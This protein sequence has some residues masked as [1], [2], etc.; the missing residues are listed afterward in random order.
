VLQFYPSRLSGNYLSGVL[1]L[2]LL[3]TSDTFDGSLLGSNLH[4][5]ASPSLV[6]DSHNMP[7]RCYVAGAKPRSSGTEYSGRRR[8][9]GLVTPLSHAPGIAL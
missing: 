9:H 4:A 2:V 5:Y 1:L 3:P 6:V 8:A 7:F